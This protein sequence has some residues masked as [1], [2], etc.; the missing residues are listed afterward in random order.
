MHGGEHVPLRI[1]HAEHRSAH[2]G[3]LVNPVTSEP[4]LR[5]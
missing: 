5:G 1:K 4:R 3:D 2:E